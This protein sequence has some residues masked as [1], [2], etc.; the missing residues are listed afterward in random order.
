MEPSVRPARPDDDGVAGLLYVSATPYYDAFA[1]GEQHARRLLAY[2]YP[3]RRH[4]ASY[5]VCHVAEIGGEVVG[6]MA[7]FPAARADALAGRFLFHAAMSLGPHRW[8]GMVRH[9]RA[10]SRSSPRPPAGTL[11]VDALAVHPGARRLG[12]A[13]ALLGRADEL[14][15]A[16]GLETVALDTGVENEAARA[17]YEA[18]GFRPTGVM[19]VARARDARAVGGSGFVS[20]A[21]RVNPAPPAACRPPGRPRPR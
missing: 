5:E 8:P 6:V 13:R 21:R 9:L 10:S 3:R 1:G 7:A 11:Y 18:A 17:A 19:H 14:A 4:A 20:Y 15:A 12:V 2:G 16:A